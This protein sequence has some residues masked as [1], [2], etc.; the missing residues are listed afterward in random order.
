ML[1]VEHAAL[2][3][4]IRTTY[5]ILVV[6]LQGMNPRGGSRSRRAENIEMDLRQTGFEIVNWIELAQDTV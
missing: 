6:K 5:D 4:K 1:W 2:A 3:G